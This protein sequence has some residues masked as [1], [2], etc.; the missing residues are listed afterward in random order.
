MTTHDSSKRFVYF[1]IKRIKQKIVLSNTI[2]DKQY[3]MKCFE[4]FKLAM[5][6]LATTIVLTVYL[7]LL[8]Y[9]LC[10]SGKN[11]KL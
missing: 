3:N 4:W 5:V 6:R 2:I 10:T 7:F 8:Q 1:E 9:D 11:E